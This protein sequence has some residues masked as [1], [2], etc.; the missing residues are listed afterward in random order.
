MRSKYL[1]GADDK[2]VGVKFLSSTNSDMQKSQ[3]TMEM[4]VMDF[5]Q[6]KFLRLPITKALKM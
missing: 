1:F 5:E 2:A 3:A 4:F 6:N